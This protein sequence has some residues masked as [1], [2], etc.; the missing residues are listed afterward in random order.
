MSL[1]YTVDVLD[2]SMFER[3]NKEAKKADDMCVCIDMYIIIYIMC[4]SC[5]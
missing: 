2:V 1:I 5:I 3:C 4:S